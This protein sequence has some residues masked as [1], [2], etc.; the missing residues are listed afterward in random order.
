MASGGS[1]S[2]LDSQRDGKKSPLGLVAMRVI[3]VITF[4]LTLGISLSDGVNDW[5]WGKGKGYSLC[6]GSGG[7]RSVS[8]FVKPEKPPVLFGIDMD[9][10]FYT[11]NKEA[12]ERNI[13]AFA[14]TRR[15]GYIPF[16]CTAK[17]LGPA[18]KRLGGPNFVERTGYRGYPGVYKNG[19]LV[20]DENGSVLSVHV[21]PK[22][23]LQA[24]HLFLVE[25]GLT[26]NV[27]FYNEDD[28]FSL[29]QD[30]EIIRT[31]PGK[32]IVP[33]FTTFE[34]LLKKNIVMMKYA[35]F[36]LNVPEFRDGIDYVDKVDINGT[37]DLSPPGV[38]KASA[39][40]TLINHYGLSSK[41]CGFI[42]DDKNDVEAMEL[43]GFSFAVGDAKDE[44]KKHAKIVLDKTCDQGAVSQALK[45]T[46]GL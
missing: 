29:A 16:L 26:A 30:N 9:G 27:I 2:A 39:L 15:R 7:S 20:Y 23:F 28:A 31:Y 25:N 43:V 1:G 4:A 18:I 12:W 11:N 19:A 40:S 46:Y 37:H 34:E 42:G 24:L 3:T 33:R 14:E 45:L 44:V 35:G 36:E 8:E 17:P 5:H 10:T 32:F 13:E 22:E 21:F 41:D 38:T 6:A